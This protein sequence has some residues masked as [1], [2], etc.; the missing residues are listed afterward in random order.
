MIY[1][2]SVVIPK[3][4]NVNLIKIT[5]TLNTLVVTS[6]LGIVVVDIHLIF[7]AV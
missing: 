1:N 5:S 2:H 3:G 7:N 4:F 6:N